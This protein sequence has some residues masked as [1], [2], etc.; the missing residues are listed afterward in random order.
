[1]NL[2]FFDVKTSEF[3]TEKIQNGRYFKWQ[4][5]LRQNP[6]SAIFSS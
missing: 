3:T 4:Q 2:M 5:N 6:E 1:M